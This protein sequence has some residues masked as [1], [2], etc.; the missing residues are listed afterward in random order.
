MERCPN[1]NAR[2]EGAD[3]S[4]RRCGM[5]LTLLLRAERAA[6]R[7]ARRAMAQLAADD[8]AAAKRSLRQSRALQQMPLASRVL[9]FIHYEEARTSA[10]LAQRHRIADANPWD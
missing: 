2:G 6:E 4:C 9:D 10:L 1:C 8:T 3:E 7:L 5:D